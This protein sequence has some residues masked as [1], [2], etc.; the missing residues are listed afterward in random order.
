MTPLAVDED[1]NLI[2]SESTQRRRTDV[3]SAV[4]N[5]GPWKIEGRRQQLD[6]LARLDLARRLDLGR[7]QNVNGHRRVENCPIVCARADDDRG[8]ELGDSARQSIV[9]L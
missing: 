9:S 8:V 2:G 3:V 7:R 4:G 1:Q 6:D 5:G